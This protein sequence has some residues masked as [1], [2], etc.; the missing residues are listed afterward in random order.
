M[1]IMLPGKDGFVILNKI[2]RESNTPVI[3]VSA[4]DTKEDNNIKEGIKGGKTEESKTF[5]SMN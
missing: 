2:R 1:D 4:K 5:K 3:I